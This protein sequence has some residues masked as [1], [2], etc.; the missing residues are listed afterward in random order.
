MIR[1][2]PAANLTFYMEVSLESEIP[3]QIILYFPL[4]LLGAFECYFGNIKGKTRKK[5]TGLDTDWI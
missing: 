4:A 3:G 2:A 5:G 1:L